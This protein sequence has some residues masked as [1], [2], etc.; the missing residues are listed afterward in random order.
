MAI[1][2]ILGITYG[3]AAAVQPG[4]LQTFIISRTLSN[5]WRYTLPS[6]CAPLVSD[7][8]IV[9]LV[10][11][12]LNSVPIWVENILHFAGGFFVLFLAWGA[13]KS[14][15]NYT[16]NQTDLLQASR[17]NFFKAVTINLLN[18][19]PY[20]SWSLVMG[21]LLLKGWREDAGNGIGLV[22]GFYFTMIF[23]T[24]GIILLFSALRRFGPKVSRILIGISAIVLACFGFYQLWLGTTALLFK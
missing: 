19:N 12:I 1:F 14:F 6:A 11:L 7:V 13:L 9:I 22:A 5:G 24:I 4:P 20:L 2:L 10:L 21:P 16:L 18:P 23:T 3:F 8:P 17:R 15:K